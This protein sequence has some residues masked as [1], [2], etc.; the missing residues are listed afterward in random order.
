[1]HEEIELKNSEIARLKEENEELTELA[2]HVH[3][4]ANMIEVSCSVDKMLTGVYAFGK[5]ESKRLISGVEVTGSI[6]LQVHFAWQM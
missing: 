4:M 6:L 2:G 1:M 3:Y 5:L